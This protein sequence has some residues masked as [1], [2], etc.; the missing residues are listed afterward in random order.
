MFIPSTIVCI[1]VGVI[2][3]FYLPETNGKSLESTNNLPT[4]LSLNDDVQMKISKI[5]E[6]THI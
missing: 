6:S 3:I 1:I 4:N 2:L 5:D